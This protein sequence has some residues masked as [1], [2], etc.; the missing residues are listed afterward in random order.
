MRGSLT[1]IRLLSKFCEYASQG[2]H[3]WGGRGGA[4]APLNL[5]N[6]NKKIFCL[7]N[8]NLFTFCPPPLVKILPPLEKTEMTSL[9]PAISI[10]TP[11]LV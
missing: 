9:T 10:K 5:K 11:I 2:R 8:F 7:Q 4:F 3:F 1:N 6:N